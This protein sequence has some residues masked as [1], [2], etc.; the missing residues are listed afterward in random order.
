MYKTVLVADF[1]E[2]DQCVGKAATAA[3]SS[4]YTILDM[5]RTTTNAFSYIGRNGANAIS[6]MGSRPTNA[7]SYM[8][9]RATNTLS[10]IPATAVPP[11]C[12]R[13]GANGMRHHAG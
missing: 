7:L 12:L 8:H 1:L 5:H 11:T 2:P 4:T 6:D 3:D 10:Y 13:N 9:G